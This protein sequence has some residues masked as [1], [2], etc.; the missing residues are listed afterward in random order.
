MEKKNG[1]NIE[2]WQLHHITVPKESEEEFK[3]YFPDIIMPP[4]I[5]TG[6]VIDEPTGRWRPGDHMRSTY[7]VSID[8]ETGVVET[9]NTMYHMDMD[10][11]GQ[12]VIPDLGNEALRIFY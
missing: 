7:I 6:T 4:I 8:R 3:K 5:F 10:T 1:G 11:E 9:L 2:K 12:D